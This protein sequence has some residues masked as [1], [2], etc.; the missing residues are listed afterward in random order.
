[1]RILLAIDTLDLGGSEK[2]LVGLARRLKDRGHDVVVL[3]LSAG[4][5]FEDEL[6]QADVSVHPLWRARPAGRHFLGFLAERGLDLY[7]TSRMIRRFCPDVLHAWLPRSQAIFLFLGAISGTRVRIA[8]RRGQY[9]ILK[10][11]VRKRLALFLS[12]HLATAATVNSLMSLNEVG[13]DVVMRQLPVALIPNGLCVGDRVANP[14]KQPPSIAVVAN[15]LAYKG[16]EDLMQAISLVSRSLSFQVNLY[17]DGPER[18]RIQEMVRTL[19]LSGIVHFHGAVPDPTDVLVASQLLVLASHTEGSP[20]VILEAR[21][22]GLPVVATRVGGVPELVEDG[23]T[24]LLVP[25]HDSQTLATA[26]E[27]MVRSPDLRV[28]LGEHSSSL[29]ESYSW[30]Q[31]T[32]L[33]ENFYGTLLS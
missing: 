12:R 3:C 17:G 11:G 4:G 25:P 10:S 16:H 26:I 24:G 15:L 13:E 29:L 21:A 1:M 14:R 8:A 28:R 2:Q 23:V 20:N 31:V 32:S 30:N 9:Q 19:G 7:R 18:T 27:L 22:V 33:Y 5:Y 6:R